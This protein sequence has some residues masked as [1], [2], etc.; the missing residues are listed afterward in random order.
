MGKPQQDETNCQTW[1]TSIRKY[2]TLEDMN[3]EVVEELIDHIEVS[4]RAVVD[5]QR[6]E[7]TKIYYRFVGLL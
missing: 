1:A 7:D 6:R 4:E 2:R 3:R 5:G